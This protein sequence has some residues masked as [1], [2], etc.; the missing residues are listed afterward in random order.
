MPLRFKDEKVYAEWLMRTQVYAVP[1][2]KAKERESSRGVSFE[3]VVLFSVLGIGLGFLGL[4]LLLS[5]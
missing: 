3:I 2:E 4:Y 5:R 1:R